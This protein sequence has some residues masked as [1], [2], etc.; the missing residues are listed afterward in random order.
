MRILGGM[1]WRWAFIA[2]VLFAHGSCTSHEDREHAAPKAPEVQGLANVHHLAPGLISGGEPAGES[3][4]AA[5]QKLGVRSLISTDAVAPDTERA[6]AAG[7]RVV[8][9]PIGYDGIDARR[10]VDLAAAMRDLPGPIYVHCHHGRHRGPAAI[11]AGAIGAGL[12]GREQAIG[13]MERAGTSRSYPGLWRDV[14]SAARI[15]DT[16]LDGILEG[17][18][19]HETPEG[20]PAVMASIDRAH[21][22]LWRVADNGWSAPDTHPDLAPA[23]D[24]GLIHDLLRSLSE[25]RETVIYGDGYEALLGNATDHAASLERS[26]LT[27]DRGASEVSLN[28]LLESCIDCHSTFRD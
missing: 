7:I 26:I 23:A 24:A 22:R 15:D 3:G 8:H 18:P 1:T 16:T 12:V 4:Y 5:L 10:R 20:T 17:L 14:G 6:E 27:G 9:L 25:S 28:L 19:S 21:E 13:F 11:A 2:A